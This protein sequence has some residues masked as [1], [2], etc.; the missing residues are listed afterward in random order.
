MRSKCGS[1]G[2]RWRRR[3]WTGPLARSLPYQH[4]RADSPSIAPQVMPS[5]VKRRPV[6]SSM[7]WRIGRHPGRPVVPARCGSRLQRPPF[8]NP[9]IST[10]VD[11][12]AL[13]Q[14]PHFRCPRQVDNLALRAVDVVAVYCVM[15]GGNVSAGHAL[16]ATVFQA[17]RPSSPLYLLHHL[18]SCVSD[19]HRTQ[20]WTSSKITTLAQCWKYAVAIRSQ[21]ASR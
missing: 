8:T 3:L 10:A 19:C 4:H 18:S 2:F 13:D 12:A 20:L 5:R 21:Q 16:P 9:Q 17:Y 14:I 1:V 7:R 11:D 15:L 6:P